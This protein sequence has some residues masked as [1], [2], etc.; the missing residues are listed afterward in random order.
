[1]IYFFVLRNEVENDMIWGPFSTHLKAL[2]F[3]AKR[4]M[5]T[6]G[7]TFDHLEES[8]YSIMAGSVDAGTQ[9]Y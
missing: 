2:D 3:I 8:L 5:S 6:D 4:F 9:I 1:M 7:N